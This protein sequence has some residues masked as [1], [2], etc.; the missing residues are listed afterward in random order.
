MLKNI[1]KN[2]QSSHNKL[3]L[4]QISNI[5]KIRPT[6]LTL[7]PCLTLVDKIPIVHSIRSL[8]PGC[9]AWLTNLIIAPVDPGGSV[10][11]WRD[12]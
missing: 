11:P 1:Y 7:M 8:A 3:M 9:P 4:L 12:F 10:T 2:L 6:H 5:G